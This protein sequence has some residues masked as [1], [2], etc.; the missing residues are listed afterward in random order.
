MAVTTSCLTPEIDSTVVVAFLDVGCM[1]EGNVS[2]GA[3]NDSA[4]GGCDGGWV[5]D[6]VEHGL[7]VELSSLSEGS[8]TTHHACNNMLTNRSPSYVEGKHTR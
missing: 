5:C 7:V 1:S 2:K 3:D 6:D 4:F 8:R